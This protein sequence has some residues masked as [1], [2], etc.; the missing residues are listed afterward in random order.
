M[1]WK[2][3]VK[4]LPKDEK[5]D[6]GDPSDRA[7]ENVKEDFRFIFADSRFSEI[8]ANLGIN[9]SGLMKAGQKFVNHLADMTNKFEGLEKRAKEKKCIGLRAIEEMNLCWM[10]MKSIFLI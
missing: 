2:E 4:N 7:R 3:I 10:I 6:G 1:S 5:Y 9:S 8:F